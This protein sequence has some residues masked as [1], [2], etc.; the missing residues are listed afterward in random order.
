MQTTR[1]HQCA[2]CRKRFAKTEHLSRHLRTHTGYR[3]FECPKCHKRFSRQD[4]LSRHM[5]VHAYSTENEG[6]HYSQA[7]QLQGSYNAGSSAM[8]EGLDLLSSADIATAA[9]GQE[10]SP[11]MYC[12]QTYVGL[13]D[14]DPLLEDL[15]LWPGMVTDGAPTRISTQLPDSTQGA[16]AVQEVAHSIREMVRNLHTY[17]SC[18][19]LIYPYDSQRAT[20]VRESWIRR[21]PSRFRPLLPRDEHPYVFRAVHSGYTGD[22]YANLHSLDNRP[23]AVVNNDGSRVSIY[24]RRGLNHQ[25]WCSFLVR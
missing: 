5:R 14:I 17:L 7:I 22:P 2:F 21:Y 23:S 15:E 19:P 11:S 20:T 12:Q 18:G 16:R 6:L 1:P 24:N 9:P 25:G 10:L 8:L 4:T 3:P 13:Q